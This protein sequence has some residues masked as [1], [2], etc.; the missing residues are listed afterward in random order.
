[1]ALTFSRFNSQN[2]ELEWILILLLLEKGISVKWLMMM[3]MLSILHK[4]KKKKNKVLNPKEFS[5]RIMMLLLFFWIG[6]DTL[7]WFRMTLSA[8]WKSIE[9]W[10]F[11]LIPCC[12]CFY[13]SF[14]YFATMQKKFIS[15]YYRLW[16]KRDFVSVF[17]FFP[18][19]FQKIGTKHNSHTHTVLL[20]IYCNAAHHD[21]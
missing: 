13:S 4:W 19:S 21:V 17:F 16:I 18:A 14:F 3:K 5:I 12:C 1:M 9:I 11:M 15:S 2:F 8:F 10:V 20:R 6:C 7:F